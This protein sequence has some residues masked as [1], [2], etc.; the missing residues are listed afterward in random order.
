MGC[1][2]NRQGLVVSL[3]RTKVRF[4]ISHILVLTAVV[5]VGITGAQFGRSP[6]QMV[7]VVILLYFLKWHSFRNAK[8]ASTRLLIHF[9][10]CIATLPYILVF[11][12]DNVSPNVRPIANWFG[13]PMIVYFVPTLSLIID[14]TARIRESNALRFAVRAGIEI[15]ILW[16]LWIFVWILIEIFVLQWVSF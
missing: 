9:V 16:P 14:E 15:L 4:S 5:A 2:C 10:A 6:W 8:L 13:T 3:T 11:A 7:P 12:T 1:S